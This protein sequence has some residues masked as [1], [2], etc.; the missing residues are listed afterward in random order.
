MELFKTVPEYFM[1]IYLFIYTR[2]F[3]YNSIKLIEKMSRRH[4]INSFDVFVIKGFT[5]L[6]LIG[7]LFLLVKDKK[8][9]IHLCNVLI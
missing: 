9:L 6:C 3:K 4:L 7:Q 2:R 5:V 8:I 1:A